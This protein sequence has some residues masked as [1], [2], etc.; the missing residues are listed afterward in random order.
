MNAFIPGI[1][2]IINGVDINAEGDTINTVS[3]AERIAMGKKPR[4]L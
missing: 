4:M 2:D 3:Y 1:A